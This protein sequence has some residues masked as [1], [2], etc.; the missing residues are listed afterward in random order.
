MRSP[1][2]S[3]VPQEMV[4]RPAPPDG[5]G[6]EVRPPHLPCSEDLVFPEGGTS[7][8]KG[9]SRAAPSLWVLRAFWL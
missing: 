6:V 2:A 7:L 1:P 9:Q 3:A 4:L 5:L 8:T